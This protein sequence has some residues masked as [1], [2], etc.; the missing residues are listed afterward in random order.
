MIL[1]WAVI[2]LDERNN[3]PQLLPIAQAVDHQWLGAI[4]IAGHDL[5]TLEIDFAT[6]QRVESRLAL[7][8]IV[9]G[10]AV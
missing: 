2:A 7:E 3:S 10:L 6:T 8:K 4:L 9:I 5:D 1:L